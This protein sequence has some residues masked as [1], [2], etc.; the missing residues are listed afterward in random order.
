MSPDATSVPSR[1]A[2]PDPASAL[3]VLYQCP[4]TAPTTTAN[5]ADI[6]R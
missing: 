4:I 5:V 2:R 3:R 1:S 6:G